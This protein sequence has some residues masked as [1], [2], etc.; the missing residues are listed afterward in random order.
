MH[1]YMDL[2][3]WVD[4]QGRFK[5]ILFDSNCPM[6]W[7]RCGRCE[8]VQRKGGTKTCFMYVWQHCCCR[9]IHWSSAES[10]SLFCTYMLKKGEWHPLPP[11]TLRSVLYSVLLF[12]VS[13]VTSATCVQFH[14]YRVFHTSVGVPQKKSPFRQ[15][16]INLKVVF[17]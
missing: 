12:I 7:L 9:W 16:S 13:A 1:I 15:E 3:L 8:N 14:A 6:C 4:R 10:C 5:I 2:M 17:M 11:S